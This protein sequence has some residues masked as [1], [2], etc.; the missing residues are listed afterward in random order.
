MKGELCS[1]ARNRAVIISLFFFRS[2]SVQYDGLAHISAQE[3]ILQ[4]S[5]P[6]VVPAAVGS[7]SSCKVRAG[8]SHPAVLAFSPNS[9]G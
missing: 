7:V 4:I 1:V 5:Y 6:E 8:E 2:I 3:E 9:W